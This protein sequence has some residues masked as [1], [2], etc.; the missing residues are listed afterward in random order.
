MLEEIGLGHRLNRR[1]R[2]MS[3]G[4]QQRVAIARA[5]IKDPLVI[6]ADEPTGNL[7]RAG[8]DRI[9]QLLR[10]RQLAGNGTLVIV[11][12]DAGVNWQNATANLPNAMVVDLVFQKKDHTLTA[13]TYGRSLWRT[14]L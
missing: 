5:L 7:D 11:T 1:P 14:K 12:H 4:E 2:Q 8:G 6:F 9:V 10:H 3:G 13:A